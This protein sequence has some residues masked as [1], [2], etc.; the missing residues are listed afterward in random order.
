MKAATN[1]GKEAEDSLKWSDFVER[2]D[3]TG[4][5]SHSHSHSHAVRGRALEWSDSCSRARRA[6]D[7]KAGYQQEASVGERSLLRL[8]CW[9]GPGSLSLV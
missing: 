3:Y 6:R 8:L 9:G 2:R 5:H 1:G 7:L 4:K